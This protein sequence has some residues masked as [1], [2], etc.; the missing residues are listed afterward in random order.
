MESQTF[1]KALWPMK[2]PQ[3]FALLA[4]LSFAAACAGDR[5]TRPGLTTLD[6]SPEIGSLAVWVS[7]IGTDLDADG[8]VLT[9]AAADGTYT[10]RVTATDSVVMDRVLVGAL[11][12]ELSDLAPN[13]WVL[14][15]RRT[16]S[17]KSSTL[18]TISFAITC[19]S[20]SGDLDSP[21]AFVGVWEAKSW[22]FFKDP[23]LSASFE[24]V[25]AGGMAGTLTVTNDGGTEIKWQWRE[26]YRWWGPDRPTVVTGHAEVGVGSL[27]SVV[28]HHV[29]EFECDWGDCAGPL[30]GEYRFV[31]T[32]SRLVITQLEPVHYVASLY[33]DRD[34]WSRLVLERVQ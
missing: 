7:T 22:E 18:T 30:H 15:R 27:R 4:L 8:Y 13:C 29:S 16:D 2:T 32:A 1:S 12:V 28:D 24:D 5:V 10:R 17:I 23:N 11:S 19:L 6:P 14:G 25:I 31:M 33:D 3:Q 34:A 9:I 20:A 21:S 26:T